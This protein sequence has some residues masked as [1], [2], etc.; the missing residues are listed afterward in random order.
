MEAWLSKLEKQ[1]SSWP[2]GVRVAIPL[3][4]AL[5]VLLLIFNAG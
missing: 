5:I 2:V 4:L 1:F 3:A